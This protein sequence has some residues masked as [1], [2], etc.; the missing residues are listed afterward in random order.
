MSP[1]VRGRGERER[2]EREEKI[3]GSYMLSEDWLSSNPPKPTFPPFIFLTPVAS[4]ATWLAAPKPPCHAALRP[5]AV[6]ALPLASPTPRPCLGPSLAAGNNHP[7]RRH[8]TALPLTHTPLPTA[9]RFL[10]FSSNTD[11]H[12]CS[13]P[14]QP[15]NPADGLSHRAQLRVASVNGSTNHRLKPHAGAEHAYGNYWVD[16]PTVQH[17]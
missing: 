13:C 2:E 3:S 11:D 10:T 17:L 5:P 7:S 9:C 8:S 14:L 6:G 12:L 4:S 1:C 15:Q 16:S